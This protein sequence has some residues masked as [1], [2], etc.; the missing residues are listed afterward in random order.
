MSDVSRSDTP[1]DPNTAYAAPIH[2]HA[3]IYVYCIHVHIPRISVFLYF[4]LYSLVSLLLCIS[5]A[6]I[7]KTTTVSISKKSYLI[8]FSFLVF[9]AHLWKQRNSYIQMFMLV[10]YFFVYYLPVTLV[11][12]LHSC[13]QLFLRFTDHCPVVSTVFP[14]QF[15]RSTTALI[16]RLPFSL[17][18]GSGSLAYPFSAFSLQ[19]RYLGASPLEI[20][21]YKFLF[22]PSESFS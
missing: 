5:L 10:R 19:V 16:R 11:S 21:M 8:L 6:C 12:V 2:A 14:V 22:L 13:I 20:L 4:S 7:I 15:L 3:H 18:S 1:V 9:I 17:S